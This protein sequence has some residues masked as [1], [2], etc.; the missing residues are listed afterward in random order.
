[1]S[2]GGS[3]TLGREMPLMLV[4]SLELGC[5]LM[6]LRVA[7]SRWNIRKTGSDSPRESTVVVTRGFPSPQGST[8]HSKHLFHCFRCMPVAVVL[9]SCCIVLFHKLRE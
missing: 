5:D 4:P 1:M 7:E 2:E 6:K 9:Y 8:E 3:K